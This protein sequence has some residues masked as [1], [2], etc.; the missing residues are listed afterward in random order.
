M[1]LDRT[2]GT[3][4]W[5]AQSNSAA[6]TTN[7]SSVTMLDTNLGAIAYGKITNGGTGPTLP[8]RVSLQISRDGTNDWIDTGLGCTGGTAN[9]ATFD[10]AIQVPIEASY[11]RLSITGNTGQAVTVSAWYDLLVSAV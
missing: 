9:S 6:A 5:S 11:W 7:G 8:A 3:S 10:F 2:A 1:P 4:Y